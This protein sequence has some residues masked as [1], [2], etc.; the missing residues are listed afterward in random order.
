MN[1]AS[2]SVGPQEKNLTCM[3]AENQ[4]KRKVKLKKVRRSVKRSD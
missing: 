3:S 1:R 4:K 2:R